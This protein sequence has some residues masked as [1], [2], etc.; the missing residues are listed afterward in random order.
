VEAENRSEASSPRRGSVF[1]MFFEVTEVTRQML[2]NV[3]AP[4][5]GEA[6]KNGSILNWV[7][8][9]KLPKMRLSQSNVIRH[10][11]FDQSKD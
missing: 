2:V 4:P 8:H 6:G 9:N 10:V 1:E 5:R 3:I 11:Y 7:N